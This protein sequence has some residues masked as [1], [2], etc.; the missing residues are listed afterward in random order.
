VG[1]AWGSPGI[2][3]A[4]RQQR[5]DGLAR[6]LGVPGLDHAA[7]ALLLDDSSGSPL[8]R[9]GLAAAIAPDLPAA[10]AAHASALLAAGQ[11]VDAT[12]AA[13]RSLGSLR[14]H[15]DSR[16][17]L[18]LAT[19][20]ALERT[21][22]W[23]G[24]LFLVVL[25][26]V[27]APRAAHDLGDL[28]VGTRQN[29]RER[30]DMPG[31]ARGALLAGVLLLPVAFGEGPLGAALAL[32]GLAFVYGDGRRRMAAAAAASLILAGLYPLG[33]VHQRALASA[34]IDPV[35]AAAYSA[36]HSVPSV[37]DAVRLEHASAGRPAAALALARTEMRAGRNE[38]ARAR[39]S[40]HVMTSQDPALLNQAANLALLLG[41][42]QEAISL[43]E[44][45][46]ALEPSPLILFNL[47]QAYGQGIRLQEQDA[48]LSR[49]QA[50]DAEV[51][52]R[53][54]VGQ[55]DLPKGVV[56][57]PVDTA[58]L[59]AHRAPSLLP[60]A[61]ARHPL[62]PGQLGS[63]ALSFGLFLLLGALATLV[64]RLYRRSRACE[65]CG[66][67]RCPRCD[68]PGGDGLCGPCARLTHSPETTD[69]GMR[70]TR[71]EDLRRRQR[72]KRRL[73][74]AVSLLVPGTSGLWTGRPLLGL[75]GMVTLAWALALVRAPAW[76]PPDP[77]SVGGAAGI[78]CGLGLGV[79]A[80]VYAGAL[81]LGLRARREG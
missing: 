24:I 71:L 10:H 46:V 12:M 8:E 55:A 2:S 63:P 79:A 78:L 41:E 18:E 66:V 16:R 56:D 42:S 34:S 22:A 54:M 23:A 81:L 35:P 9:A 37:R 51:V 40:P 64:P 69:P 27:A 20:E 14:R 58:S 25:G 38:E 13:L 5:L 76:L 36:L 48:A 74:V 80:L 43:Y 33:Q 39:L 19:L 70:M 50:L 57:L 4:A 65:R 62:A 77:G 60:A 61:R 26:A 32:F 28:A 3:L 72:R 21:L 6:E 30:T 75:V 17:W 49:A 11:L 47:S 73:S 44:R 59:L 29:S 53:L 31:F 45:A 68:P 7:S 15:F 52:T 1:L 67:R